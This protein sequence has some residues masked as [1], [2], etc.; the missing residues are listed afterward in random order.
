MNLTNLEPAWRQYKVINSLSDI[1]EAEILAA[2][3]P[4]EI[5]ASRPWTARIAQNVF[6]YSVLIFA[7]HGCVV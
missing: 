3:E 4:Q 7:L 6:A 1:P 5:P 2:I